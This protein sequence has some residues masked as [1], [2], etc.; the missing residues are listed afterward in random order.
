ME[1]QMSLLF[2]VMRICSKQDRCQR[3]LSSDSQARTARDIL[4]VTGGAC[5]PRSFRIHLS[6]IACRD[7][8]PTAIGHSFDFPV[9]SFSPR[10][11]TVLTPATAFNSTK[12]ERHG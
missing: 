1:I 2:R 12:E 3:R 6:F 7:K 5:A 9:T 8:K 11:L 10:A 4:Q